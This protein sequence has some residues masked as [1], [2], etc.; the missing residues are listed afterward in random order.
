MKEKY[1][2]RAEI[3]DTWNAFSVTYR[4]IGKLWNRDMMPYK[5]TREQALN[6]MII[7]HLG[8]NATPYR[9]SRFQVQEHNTVSD[10]IERLEK[11]GLVTKVRESQGKSRVKVRLTKQG[12]KVYNQSLRRHSLYKIMSVLSSSQMKELRQILSRL[13]D[14]IMKE[15]ETEKEWP[16]IRIPPSQWPKY[17]ASKAKESNGAETTST[18]TRRRKTGTRKL[19]ETKI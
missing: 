12:E 4:L 8:E 11:Q 19:A 13:M 9:I 14:E 18:R 15:F 7:K 10:M 5:I 17:I 6:L 16:E 3:H 1:D 2:K